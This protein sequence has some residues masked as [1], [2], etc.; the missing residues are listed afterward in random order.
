MNLKPF[1]INSNICFDKSDIK[2]F[3]SFMRMIA[4][5]VGNS[6]ITYSLIKEL[7]GGIVRVP[8]IPN[9]Y[10]YDFENTDKDVEYI[11]GEC[12]HVFLIMQDQIRIQESY[13]LKLPY[14]NIINFIKKL[15]KPVIVAGLGANS[16]SPYRSDFYKSLSDDLISFLQ[17]L[18][19]HCIEIG[20]RGEYTQD[21]LHNIGVDNVRVIGC[22][23]FYECGRVRVITPKPLLTSE[24]ILLTHYP[25]CE[26]YRF[27]EVFQVL[28]EETLIKIIAYCDFGE[29]IDLS[30]DVLKNLC[31]KRYHIFSNIDKWKNF[32]NNFYFE[33][34]TRLHGAILALNS[35]VPAVCLNGDLRATEM[36][37][38][39]KI[40]HF[41]NYQITDID[42]I[43]KLYEKIDI[44]ELNNA[45]PNLYQN[46]ETFCKNNNFSLH[47]PSDVTSYKYLTLPSLPLYSKF[48]LSIALTLLFHRKICC[49]I[50][51][52]KRN[53]QGGNTCQ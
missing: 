29:N 3:Y 50:N 44:S 27:H 1:F 34:G 46:F 53:I 38:F 28:Q 41:P 14:S 35:G 52:I 6:Y 5:N 40:P 49:T 2:D 4:G 21:I 13:G 24:K 37:Q 9:I 15:N 31:G 43:F 42:D 18:S 20:V 33:F 16:F 32:V 25:N 47:K 7:Y 26:S 48:T 30:L 12:S 8:H 22:P 36:C 11:N 23:S 51:R 39:L 17:F 10:E 19:Q 45:Y